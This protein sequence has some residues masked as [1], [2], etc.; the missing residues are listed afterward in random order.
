ML[1]ASTLPSSA[2]IFPRS[3]LMIVVSCH[4]LSALA[5]HSDAWVTVVLN[6]RATIVL[7]N[8]RRASITNM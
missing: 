6:R 4:A 5:F 7:E 8:A 3:A 1:A 2:R